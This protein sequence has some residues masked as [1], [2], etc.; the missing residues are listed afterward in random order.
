[1]GEEFK[2]DD[3]IVYGKTGVCRLVGKQTM[4]FGDG[5]GEYYVL[6]P[7]G[8]PASSLYVP[9]DNPLLMERLRPLL[10]KQQIEE[11]L[12]GMDGTEQLWI[13]DRNE[14]QSVFR[15]IIVGDDRLQQIRLIRCLHH[16]RQEKEM[17]GRRLSAMDETL[18]QDAVRLV[19]EEFS[20]A[21][22]IPRNKVSVYI[23]DRIGK[24]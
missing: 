9:C 2:K 21:L 12:A 11:L 24:E 22:D 23:I 15:R 14:R 18:L 16:K 13:G 4:S 7:I 17:A 1:M 19:E 20:L 8:D 5:S 6:A 10:T 3:Y